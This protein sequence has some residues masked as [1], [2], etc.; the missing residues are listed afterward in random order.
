MN[1]NEE[2]FEILE[3]LDV[4]AEK[5]QAVMESMFVGKSFPL[6]EEEPYPRELMQEG[7]QIVIEA[8][9][10]NGIEIT[11]YHVVPSITEHL[12][13]LNVQDHFNNTFAD[14]MFSMEESDSAVKVESVLVTFK[15]GAILYNREEQA[16]AL[17]EENDEEEIEEVQEDLV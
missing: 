6:Q 9:V 15:P 5:T 11:G 8:G 16:K 4:M 7:A 13:L 14:I 1:T 12:Y 17:L 3:H 10:Q 2:A